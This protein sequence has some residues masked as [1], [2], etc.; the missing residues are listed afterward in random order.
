MFPFYDINRS[1]RTPYVVRLLVL[2]N[3]AVFVWQFFLF[4]DP[5]QA[6]LQY[7]FIPSRFWADPTSEWPRIFTSMFMHGGLMH[8]LG[9]MWFLWVFGD[10]IEDRMGHF[11]FLVFY[12]LGG[13]AAALAQGLVFASTDAPMVGASGAISAVL[14]AYIMLFPRATVLSLVG[15]IPLPV[16]AFIYLGYWALIQLLQNFA[17]VEGIAFW[18]HIGGFIFGMVLVRAFVLS[19]VSRRY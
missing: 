1:H 6:I 3:I 13:V 2:A 5:D 14:G 4:P 16:P 10:N 19:Q 12:L 18:A 11:R 7:G 9:N 15:W 8:I 17:G